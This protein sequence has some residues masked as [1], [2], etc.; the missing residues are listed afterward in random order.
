M[1][2]D[3][4]TSIFG[5]VR[6]GFVGASMIAITAAFVVAPAQAE[7][8]SSTQLALIE[9]N[10]TPVNPVPDP[11]GVDGAEQNAATRAL[12]QELE[13]ALRGPL[14][15]K[16]HENGDAPADRTASLHDMLHRTV[17][18][19]RT[20]R[21]AEITDIALRHTDKPFFSANPVSFHRLPPETAGDLD[22]AAPTKAVFTKQDE[23]Q[24]FDQ[25]VTIVDLS[26]QRVRV[27]VEGELKHTWKVST[28][29]NGKL[30]PPGEW[31][32][33][34]HAHH[35]A[36]TAVQHGADAPLGVLQWRHCLPRHG[37]NGSPWKPR[38]RGLCS[39]APAERADAVRSGEE[40][41]NGRD[42]RARRAL[43]SPNRLRNR[44][45]ALRGGF[46]LSMVHFCY[47]RG[48]QCRIPAPSSARGSPFGPFQRVWSFFGEHQFTKKLQ[49][50]VLWGFRN[51]KPHAHS[52]E[53]L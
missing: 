26:E 6:A 18:H 15:P 36:F 12:G 14:S 3:A 52:L 49:A 1:A 48:A 29:R 2:F 38:E 42:D 46:L 5:A 41:Q 22:E 40:I 30:T 53:A 21:D 24:A 31:R 16:H 27:Y 43:I 25:L 10:A 13:F 32:P 51:A 39:P 33:L 20:S 9:N 7:D 47:L 37:R 23:H 35:V 4:Q 19:D 11:A 8:A 17:V 44:K 28:G 50:A 45:A 34:S